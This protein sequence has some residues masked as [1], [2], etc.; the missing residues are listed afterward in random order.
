MIRIWIA[1]LTGVLFIGCAPQ[2]RVVYK[3]VYIPIKCDAS[4]PDKPA[5]TRD[6]ARDLANI[7]IYTEILE[8]NLRYCMNSDKDLRNK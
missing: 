4:L 1:I 2:T 7:L 6:L 3:D 8:R 5:Q